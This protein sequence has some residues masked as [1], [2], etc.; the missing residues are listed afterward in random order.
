MRSHLLIAALLLGCAEPAPP[1]ASPPPTASTEPAT[2][3]EAD[4]A[5][6]PPLTARFQGGRVCD[7][8]AVQALRDL[9]GRYGSELVRDALLVA[10]Q[11]CNAPAALAELLTE[12]LPD[13]P[14]FE[15]S[16]QLGV[17]WIRATQYVQ[18]ADILRPL[19]EASP[20]GSNARW[21]AGFALVH[22]GEPEAALPWLDE[23][24][25]H[26]GGTD[27]SEAHLL[28]GL[29]KL[30]LGDADG[31]VPELERARELVPDDP[32]A[33]SALARAY[34]GAG[35]DAD[36]QR[37]AAEAQEAHAAREAVERRNSALSAMSTNLKSA[38]SAQN[39]GE[40]ERVIDQMWPLA[41]PTIR[42]TLQEY[43]VQL[44]AKTGRPDEAKEAQAELARL[45]GATP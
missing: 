40:V 12:T 32:S 39:Y 36:G 24:R 23:A 25:S 38:W 30:Q 10:Y 1:P 34:A 43:R 41:P 3:S 17:A 35:R 2:P 5:R 37:V 7:A 8:D 19:A 18:A 33:L 4:R 16:L 22:A 15:Q 44:Y 14:T 45:R 27:G 29:A 6:V 21:L 26:A 42:V 13:E 20:A 11:A 9:R 28:I 31:A